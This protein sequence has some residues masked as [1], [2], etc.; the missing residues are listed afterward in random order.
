M[1][2][3]PPRYTL[4]PYTTLFRSS[5]KFDTKKS[6]LDFNIGYIVTLFLGAC[7]IA[8]G[9]LVMYNSGESFSGSA[10]EF[11]S[12]LINLYTNTIGD[13]MYIVIGVAAFTTMFSTTLTILDA[14]PRAMVRTV[15]LLSKKSSK[16]AYWFW[17]IFLATGTIDRK[18]VV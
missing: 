9:A 15:E 2:R 1:I 3:R 10:S 16:K 17:I 12:Q 11:A 4:F 5:T 7:F 8:L 18:S 13:S 14:S 6:I